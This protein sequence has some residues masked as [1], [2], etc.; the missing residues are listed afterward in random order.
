M[1]LIRGK[2]NN[3]YD[4]I[5]GD[6][7]GESL[8]VGFM[9]PWPSDTIPY[10]WLL[11]DGQAISRTEYADLFAVLG[12]SHGVGDGS[13]TFNVPDMRDYTVVG[14]SSTDGNINA[15]GEKYG[16][17]THTLTEAQMP[18]HNHKIRSNFE[19]GGTFAAATLT[20]GTAYISSDN[21]VAFN[22]GGGEAHNNMQPSI[23]ENYIIKAKQSSGVVANV[24]DDLNSTST[25]DALSANQGRLLNEKTI[26]DSGNNANGSWIKY[27]DGTMICYRKVAYSTTF[28]S[29]F[30]SMFR[31]DTQIRSILFPQQFVSTNDLVVTASIESGDFIISSFIYDIT[32][33]SIDEI[34]LLRP[35]ASATVRT[36]FITIIAIGRW[37]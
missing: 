22:T 35:A 13:T 34:G 27:S 29:A 14:K 10:G 7:N 33:S 31:N 26:Y 20:T 16:A 4:V 3:T 2:T 30:G 1:S 21:N 18:S 37:K 19:T 15:I 9:G 36:G 24:V 6:F 8:P 11:C 28:N 17:K 5:S 32:T 23:A 25:V 12:T